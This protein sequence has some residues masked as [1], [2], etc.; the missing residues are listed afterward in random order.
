M[1]AFLA[2]LLRRGLSI[3]ITLLVISLALYA[4]SMTFTPEERADLYFPK[5]VGKNFKESSRPILINRIIDE[6][7]LRDPFP[8][9]Y[10]RWVVHLF[11]GDWGYSAT[12]RDEVLSVLLR[13]T[14]ATAELTLYSLVLFFP[15][16]V[17]SG[18]ISGWKRGRAPDVGF[19]SIAAIATSLPPF[20]LAVILLSTFYVW[21][22][23]FMPERL[24]D[25]TRLYLY[26]GAFQTYTGL[27]T[28]DG[29]L[30]GRPDISLEALRH[31]VLPV[32]TLSFA[33][34]AVVGRITRAAMIE[35]LGKDY[36]TS[37]RARGL[38]YRRVIWRHTLR[39]VVSPVLNSSALSATSLITGLFIIESIFNFQGISTF[40]RNALLETTP[41][42]PAVLGFSIYST[43]MVLGL[44]LV[45]DI[46]QALL[47]PRYQEGMGQL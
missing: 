6:Y 37:A 39:N 24:G 14:P 34:W 36:V 8:A 28:I 19:R 12:A 29:L 20:L 23:W 21:L 31:L 44:M 7:G 43:L 16:G 46:L 33:Q 9:Q 4:V 13:L 5:N 25:T 15:L 47:D 32:V 3:L 1:P 45:M 22:H 11:Q 17:I 26:S 35:E 40:L 41:D 42:L 27:L 30:N 10:S 2:F 38:P 18:V